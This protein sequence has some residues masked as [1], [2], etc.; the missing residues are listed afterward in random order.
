VERITVPFRHL[1]LGSVGSQPANR[2]DKEP[3][4]Q[5]F[6]MFAAFLEPAM[7]TSLRQ[8]DSASSLGAIVP[9]GIVVIII[10][11]P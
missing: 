8:I 3:A 6:L 4:A 2:I 11:P 9:A 5:Y 1:S 10:G 7:M